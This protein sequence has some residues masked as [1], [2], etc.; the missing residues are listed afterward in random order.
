[1]TSKNFDTNN[2]LFN[3]DSKLGIYIIHGFSSTTYEVKKLAEYLGQQGYYV[4]ADNLPGHSTSIEDCN[5]TTHDEWLNFVEKEIASM[6]TKCDKVIV[7]G[8]SM[9]GVL[10]LHLAS[11]FP[12]DG[13]VVAGALFKF[14]NEFNVR[15]LVRLLHRFKTTQPKRKSFTDEQLKIINHQF[16]GYDHYPLIALNEMRKMIDKVK[17]KLHKISSPILL[18]HSKIDQTATFENFHIIK[19]LLK[20]S[21]LSTL[22]LEKTGHH[23]FDTEEPDKEEILSNIST[24]TKNIF[25]D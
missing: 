5:L 13:A 18:I 6:Y 1:M 9:G 11:I 23:V 7:M 22:I 8:V 15:V 14:K 21:K 4:K 19:N 10:T 16:Y 25:N 20:N 12:L 24:F 2:Y 17:E 3:P